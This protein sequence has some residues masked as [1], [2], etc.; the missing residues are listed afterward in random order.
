MLLTVSSRS[1]YI[2]M[3]IRHVYVNIQ[4]G[5]Y[6][7]AVYIY[8]YR[9]GNRRIWH[10]QF[11]SHCRVVEVIQSHGEHATVYNRDSRNPHCRACAR[12]RSPVTFVGTRGRIFIGSHVAPMP[13]RDRRD[14]RSGFILFSISSDRKCLILILWRRR[15]IAMDCLRRVHRIITLCKLT[16][17]FCNMQSLLFFAD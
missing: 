12:E 17:L 6:I 2:S 5:P 8:V 4:R 15:V 13:T 14:L 11:C 16:N 7:C 10:F 1:P 9:R 3:L